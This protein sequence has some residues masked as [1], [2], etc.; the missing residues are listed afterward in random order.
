MGFTEEALI[1]ACKAM[2]EALYPVF[3]VVSD[4]GE[5]WNELAPRNIE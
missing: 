3:K 1:S 5:V 2:W 4:L